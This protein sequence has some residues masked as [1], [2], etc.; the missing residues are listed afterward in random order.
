MRTCLAKSCCYDEDEP[1][2]GSSRY[3]RDS[4]ERDIDLADCSQCF[5]E[6]EDYYI[7]MV[8]RRKIVGH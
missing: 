5:L 4:C 1:W 3:E 8:Q 2:C 7:K 6:V